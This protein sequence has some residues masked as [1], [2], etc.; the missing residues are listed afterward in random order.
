MLV[1]QVQG[2]GN[3][4]EA[5]YA[6]NALVEEYPADRLHNG[7][8]FALDD[9]AV[10]FPTRGTSGRPDLVPLTHGNLLDSAWALSL[11]TR[12]TSEEVLLRGLSHFFQ[13]WWPATGHRPSVLTLRRLW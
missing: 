6:F 8:E 13:G 2:P 9:L 11:V 4:R 12:F 7:R 1:L 10:S 5:A 3:E